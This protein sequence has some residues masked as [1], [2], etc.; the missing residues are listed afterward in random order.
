M[1]LD[2]PT[3]GLDVVVQ[4][5]ILENVRRLQAEQGFAVLFISHDIGTVLDLS[6]RMLV[7]Y[8]GEIVEEQPAERLLRDPMHPYTQ[9]SARLVR[10]PARRDRRGSPTSRAGRR[11]S[12]TGRRAAPSRR[13]A[14]SGSTVCTEQS[15]RRSS[16]WTA[17]EVACHVAALQRSEWTRGEAAEVGEPI[18]AAFAGP[19]FVKTARRVE[20]A[21]ANEVLLSVEDVTKTFVSAAG[22]QRQRGPRPSTTSSFVL[23]RGEVTALVGQSGSGKSTLARMITGVERPDPGPHPLPRSRTATTWS[24]AARAALREYRSD[25]QMVFQDPY[26]A[27][28]PAKTLGYILAGRW[29]TTRG[30]SG[31]RCGEGASSCWRRSR[32]P[33]PSGTSTGSRTSC[34]VGSASGW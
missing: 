4:H 34:P 23:R 10:R 18:T 28:N 22:L 1:L 14:R 16:R 27:L 29:S 21:L 30:S 9:G 11:T 12:A 7:M 32:S 2:E 25:V 24:P 3:T 19:Q 13:A 31:A 33:R 26:S 20:E 8:A 17:D 6:D 15:T 5:T